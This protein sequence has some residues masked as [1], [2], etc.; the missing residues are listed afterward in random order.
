MS[1]DINSDPTKLSLNKSDIKH[2][3]KAPIFQKEYNENNE[4][5]R[6]TQIEDGFC[7]FP[8]KIQQN[9]NNMECLCKNH[10]IRIMEIYER[11]KKSIRKLDKSEYKLLQSEK[12]VCEIIEEFSILV[13]KEL[14][15][16]DGNCNTVSKNEVKSE[17]LK[18]TDSYEGVESFD[19]K[20]DTNSNNVV[21]SDSSSGTTICKKSSFVWSND[22]IDN[23]YYSENSILI[24]EKSKMDNSKL[25]AKINKSIKFYLV[26]DHDVYCECTNENP[27]SKEE[28]AWM[29]S[30]KN[31]N[32]SKKFYDIVKNIQDKQ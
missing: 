14:S 22:I 3:I 17:K 26:G 32:D 4:E 1:F 18:D 23:E 12:K 21:P 19:T 2:L 15:N 11:E 5:E 25:I 20:K 27:T 30:F 10:K 8:I 13:K 28:K 6:I 16:F 29:M 7:M 31:E 24:I 9:L